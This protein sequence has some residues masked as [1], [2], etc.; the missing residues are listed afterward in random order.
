MR[1]RLKNRASKQG[2]TLIELLAVIA[3]IGILASI[4]VPNVTRYIAKAKV[5]KAVAEI[6]NAE[7]ALVGML[8][9][10]G[11]TN[12][13]DMLLRRSPPDLN[14]GHGRLSEIHYR[15]ANRG[16]N[17]S[18]AATAAILQEALDFYNTM[19]YELL[20]QGRDSEW[21]Q[22]NIDPKVL[23]KLGTA[24]I[25]I[26]EDSWGNPYEFW[27]GARP[28]QLN[29]T[30]LRSYRVVDGVN[31]NDTDFDAESDGYIWYDEQRDIEQSRLPGQPS[32][33]DDDYQAAFNDSTVRAYGQPAPKDLPV[34]I[35]SRGANLTIDAVLPLQL[36]NNSDLEEFF[37]GG[38]DP[39]NWDNEGGWEDA[40]K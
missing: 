27:I 26:G 38:D 23:N 12:F 20:R 5:T 3:I 2:F 11:R 29:L 35:F 28:R 16:E 39:N 21:A 25:D 37:G 1:K 10:A 14:V 30:L 15:L 13:N 36:A 32:A 6:K 4:V 34:Y 9:D 18:L 24:Y 22:A 40:P 7:T 17:G 19:F 33:D 31:P 8:S